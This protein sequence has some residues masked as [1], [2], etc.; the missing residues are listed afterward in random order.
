MN[1]VRGL[2]PLTGRVAVRINDG[3]R[4][5]ESRYHVRCRRHRFR[6]RMLR[7]STSI[8]ERTSTARESGLARNS[9]GRSPPNEPTHEDGHGHEQEHPTIVP[10]HVRDSVRGHLARSAGTR[11]RAGESIIRPKTVSRV[12][13]DESEVEQKSEKRCVVCYRDSRCSTSFTS[14]KFTIRGGV[15]THTCF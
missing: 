12:A 10:L 11:N 4:V 8:R 5:L 7:C 14:E 3:P 1:S 9:R 13:L 6:S 2:R 15:K